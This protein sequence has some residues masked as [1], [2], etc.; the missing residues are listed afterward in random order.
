[1]QIKYL[2]KK[3]KEKFGYSKLVII[4][5]FFAGVIFW[6]WHL[7]KITPTSTPKSTVRTTSKQPSAQGNFSTGDKRNPSLVNKEEGTIIDTRGAAVAAGQSEEWVR[8]A[9]GELVVFS[10][11]SGSLLM[12]GDT[13]S[14]R[15]NQGQ[16][17]YRLIDNLSGQI[18]SGNLTVVNGVFSGKFNF[19]S[20]A[21][22]G[23]VDVFNQATDGTESNNVA[24]KVRFR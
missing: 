1:M 5:L 13:L 22:E 23:Q 16:V 7:H 15:S 24:I 9:N 20:A 21:A 6:G 19:S 8:S 2:V 14:G 18:A 4:V 3:N 10:P 11:V 12:S 17:S